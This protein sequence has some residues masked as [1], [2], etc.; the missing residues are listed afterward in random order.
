M[1]YKQTRLML[2]TVNSILHMLR[3]I[4]G[5]QLIIRTINIRFTTQL[6]QKWL[7]TVTREI[8]WDDVYVT[9]PFERPYGCAS[10]TNLNTAC[11]L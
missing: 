4:L 11:A 9:R 8:Y 7:T 3:G 10:M 5:K 6:T 1:K 2:T